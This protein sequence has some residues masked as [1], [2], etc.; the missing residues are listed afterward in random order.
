MR[1]D[2]EQLPR[3]LKRGLA[4][5]YVVYGEELLLALEA[6]DRIRAAAAA[7]GHEERKV[8]IAEAGFDWNEALAAGANLSLFASKR[9]LDLRIPSGKPGKEGAE[10]LAQL[11]RSLPEDTIVLIGLPELDRQ[12]LASAWFEALERA[13]VAVHAAAV[14]RERL[15]QWIGQRLAAQDQHASEETLHFVAQRVEGNLMAAH[16]EVMKLAL[17]FPPGELQFEDVKNAVL[18]VARFDVFELGPAILR[19][20]R[21]HFVRMLDGLRAEG[22]APPLVLWAIAEEAR[23]M[24]RIKRLVARGAPLPHA[25]REARVW[26]PRQQ[27]MPKAL[28]RLDQASLLEALAAAAEVDRIIKGLSEGDAWDALLRLG[29]ALMPEAND[30]I[31][32]R[33]SA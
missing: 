23:V 14:A 19:G 5:L 32:G 17:L 10:A 15:P 26:G 8:L 21:A 13:G 25:M 30:G 31:G 12:A 22:V 33:I 3:Q 1:I 28:E 24:A 20:E 18:D 29:L 6:A 4:P 9:L 11:A 2:S 7:A 27:W 16:Q